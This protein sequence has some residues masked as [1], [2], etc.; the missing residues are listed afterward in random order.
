[1]AILGGAS[2]PGMVTHRGIPW[3]ALGQPSLAILAVM[4]N[5]TAVVMGL[6]QLGQEIASGISERGGL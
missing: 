1:M 5:P 6:N 4:S 2:I 3:R